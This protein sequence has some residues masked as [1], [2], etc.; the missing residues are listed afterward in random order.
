MT[1]PAEQVAA[2]QKFDEHLRHAIWLFS[3]L[4]YIVTVLVLLVVWLVWWL[5]RRRQLRR[6]GQHISGLAS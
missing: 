6:S 3:R 1:I 2:A 5:V 4:P